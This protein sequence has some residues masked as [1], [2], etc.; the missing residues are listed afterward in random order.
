M[1]TDV[2]MDHRTRN[3]SLF[4]HRIFILYFD[5]YLNLAI[6]DSFFFFFEIEFPHL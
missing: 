2:D 4:E 3:A 5:S 6:S 1:N